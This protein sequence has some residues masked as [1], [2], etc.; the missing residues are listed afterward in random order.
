MLNLRTIS[1]LSCLVLAGGLLALRCSTDTASTPAVKD[2]GKDEDEDKGKESATAD[3]SGS[4]SRSAAGS[5]SGAKAQAAQ[6]SGSTAAS[7]KGS[8]EEPEVAPE[9]PADPTSPASGSSE[10]AE[11]VEAGSGSV[12]PTVPTTCSV[13]AGLD[14]VEVTFSTPIETCHGQGRVWDFFEERCGAMP[15]AAT[16]TW[17][18]IDGATAVR[19]PPEVDRTNSKLVWCGTADG[20][21][22]V[23]AQFLVLK[24]G[25]TTFPCVFDSKVTPLQAV[26]LTDVPALVAGLSGQPHTVVITACAGRS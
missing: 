20:G 23:I 25:V 15:R 4:A 26:C 13:T 24:A 10:P 21:H 2:K 16:C 18:F 7:G 11:Q 17:D 5:G 14:T 12:A 3:G 9:A 1:I 6:D 22:T 19:L 8:A